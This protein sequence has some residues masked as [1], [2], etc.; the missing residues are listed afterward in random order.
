MAVNTTC[1]YCGELFP[2][3]DRRRRRRCPRCQYRLE[4]CRRHSYLM[5][6]PEEAVWHVPPGVRKR[7]P[8]WPTYPPPLEEVAA[9]IRHWRR[10]PEGHFEDLSESS[11]QAWLQRKLAEGC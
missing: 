3:P 2:S 7:R 5:S 10:T 4:V 9:T 8:W 11:R 6:A 1:L